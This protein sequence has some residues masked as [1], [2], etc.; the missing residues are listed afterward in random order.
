M[1][2]G[3]LSLM[4]FSGY[5]DQTWQKCSG[6][7]S[8]LNWIWMIWGWSLRDEPFRHDASR[9]ILQLKT[10]V[11]LLKRVRRFD[12]LGDFLG[13]IVRTIDWSKIFGMAGESSLASCSDCL[14]S[15]DSGTSKQRSPLLTIVVQKRI[16]KHL[17][18]VNTVRYTNKSMIM[19]RVVGGG[20][21]TNVKI[22]SQG[23]WQRGRCG[24]CMQLLD[25]FCF[26]GQ[27]TR[28]KQEA[29]SRRQCLCLGSNLH[30]ASWDIHMEATAS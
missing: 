29:S 1:G 17:V 14:L 28:N 9:R 19:L 2:F 3:V 10:L 13:R 30:F 21:F 27:A 25:M 12:R 23:R 15:P 26:H 11:Q 4:T 20:S 18:L 5:P 6:P 7:I 24:Y 16:S 8:R 22:F